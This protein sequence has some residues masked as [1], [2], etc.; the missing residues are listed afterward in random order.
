MHVGLPSLVRF[1]RIGHSLAPAR[2]TNIW[3]VN[4]DTHCDVR[5]TQLLSFMF[6]P[7]RWF[8]ADGSV[9]PLTGETH[10]VSSATSALA[11]KVMAE[12][13]LHP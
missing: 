5:K 9:Q 3:S 1:T 13:S 7:G 4:G 2:A 10:I 12:G 6:A 8:V 11:S